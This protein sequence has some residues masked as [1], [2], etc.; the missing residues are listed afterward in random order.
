MP[1]VATT[2]EPLRGHGPAGPAF[3]RFGRDGRQNLWD[4]IGNPR[5]YEEARRRPAQ[6]A[7]ERATQR[8][9]CANWGQK[10]TDDRWRAGIAVDWGRGDSHPH[11]RPGGGAVCVATV[12][13]DICSP[14]PMSS[15]PRLGLQSRNRPTRKWSESHAHRG[16]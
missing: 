6:E 8:P 11:L 7:D 5:R 1:I 2:L 15:A 16:Q 9:V 14:P 4:T 3:W 13:P 10:F 12:T